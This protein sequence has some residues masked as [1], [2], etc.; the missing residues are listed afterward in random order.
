MMSSVLRGNGVEEISLGDVSE[1]NLLVCVWKMKLRAMV[2]W[3]RTWF[4]MK[5]KKSKTQPRNSQPWI[6]KKE[7]SI[8]MPPS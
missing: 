1:E 4:R 2:S 3:A 8:L 7:L 6:G 5:K